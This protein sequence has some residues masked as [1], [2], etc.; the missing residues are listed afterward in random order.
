MNAAFICRRPNAEDVLISGFEVGLMSIFL[1]LCYLKL[2]SNSNVK[3]D[4]EAKDE[5]PR[6]DNF[7]CGCCICQCD[8]RNT[9]VRLLGFQNI[10][11]YFHIRFQFAVLI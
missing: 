3:L 10:S 8:S 11:T 5:D 7:S 9:R 6:P 2:G 4:S 1:L